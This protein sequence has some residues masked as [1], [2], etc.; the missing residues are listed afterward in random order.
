MLRPAS[1][2]IGLSCLQLAGVLRAQQPSVNVYDDSLIGQIRAAATAVSGELPR[3]IRYLKFAEA[4][5]RLSFLIEGADS[6][7]VR[8]AMAVFQISYPKRWIIVDAG[9][10]RRTFNE[11]HPKDPVTYWPERWAR[12]QRA[13]RGADAIVLTHE[14]WDHAIGVE[15]GPQ[16]SA[17]A[18]KTFV[19]A[20]QLASLLDPPAD[21]YVRLS[22][23]SVPPYHKIEY[24]RLYPVSAGVVLVKAPGHTPGSQWVYVKLASGR[25][26]L[27]VGDLVWN[28]AA[29]RTGKQ[30]PI[31]VSESLKEDR[32]ALQ[33]QIDFV[34]HFMATGVTVIT[35][36]DDSALTALVQ[37]GLLR[38]ELRLTRA[39]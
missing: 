13:F 25:E 17:L 8:I 7:P 2:V 33:K 36:H 28:M 23:D 27:L 22:P 31:S 21:A 24:A 18:A 1:F 26:F 39:R 38:N 15:R 34:R 37:G 30:R 14:H 5:A 10:D 19:T 35:A 9:F 3:E 29:L 11:L 6:S 32:G 20:E 12:I 16:V 4:P